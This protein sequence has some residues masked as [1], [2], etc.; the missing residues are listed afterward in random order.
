MLAF[1]ATFSET[2]LDSTFSEDPEDDPDAPSSYSA[3]YSERSS[4]SQCSSRSSSSQVK[5][6][7]QLTCG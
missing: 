7:E 4:F 2:I 1:I 5:C 3:T 6:Y